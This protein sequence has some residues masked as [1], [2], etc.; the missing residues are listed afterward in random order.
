MISILSFTL[1]NFYF[2]F[3]A[4]LGGLAPF[5]GLYL[6]HLNYSHIEIGQLMSIL[7][8]TKVIAPNLWSWVGDRS[9]NRLA[10]VRWGSF[11]AFLIFSGFLFKQ[12]FGWAVLWM[13]GFS[14][15]WNAVLPQYEVLTLHNLGAERKRYSHI[16][17]WGSVGFIACVIL[18]GGLFESVSITA[19][20]GILLGI[21]FLIWLASLMPV[22]QPEVQQKS[23]FSGFGK[24]LLQPAVPAFFVVNLLLQI[25]H[26]P[27]YSFFSI[28]LEGHG[29]S[30][31][32]IG[33]LWG[34]GVLAEVVLFVFMHRILHRYS[35]RA[36]TLIALLLTLVRWLM[37]AYLMNNEWALIVAQIG[38][39]ASFGI[40]HIV[41]IHF[42]HL[43]FKGSHEGQGQA[44]YSSLSF[45]LG[46]ALGALFSGYIAEH[47]SF[48]W[49]FLMA[50]ACTAGALVLAF[51]YFKPARGRQWVD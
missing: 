28:A 35:L 30:K 37:T 45:G 5:W 6:E 36:L 50:A 41:A 9:G 12:T 38:H 19:L 32:A 34:L 7:M 44:L 26:G 21:L 46:G 51:F 43:H 23:G 47:S 39:A 31:T 11:F 33:M 8:I 1:S 22:K 10:L 3:F 20:P 40:M 4:L 15:F 29:F 2:W 16:R 13:V 24:L 14:F 42:V 48:E 25:S 18:L 17:L 27:Y 49:L